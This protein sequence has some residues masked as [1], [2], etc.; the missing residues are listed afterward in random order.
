M[1]SRLNYI[2]IVSII[3]HRVGNPHFIITVVRKKAAPFAEMSTTNYLIKDVI[4]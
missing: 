1:R 3:L 4:K 2:S